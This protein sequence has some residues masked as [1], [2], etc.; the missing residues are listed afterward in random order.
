[1]VRAEDWP[2]LPR[3]WHEFEL[4]A[5]DFFAMKPALDPPGQS[6]P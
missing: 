3:V 5:F 1:V 4:K 2:V 6:S